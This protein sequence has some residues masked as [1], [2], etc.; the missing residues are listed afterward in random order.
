MTTK[1]DNNNNHHNF[2][3]LTIKN[4]RILEHQNNIFTEEINS[5]LNNNSIPYKNYS[6][7]QLLKSYSQTKKDYKKYY[8]NGKRRNTSPLFLKKI[9]LKSHKK[10]SKY[11]KDNIYNEGLKLEGNKSYENISLEKYLNEIDIYM[12][13][14]ENKLNENNLYYL[15][16]NEKNNLTERLKLTPIP[17]KSRIL[18]KTNK[19]INDLSS[20]ER[21]AVMLRRVEYTHGFSS[22]NYKNQFTDKLNRKRKQIYLIMKEAVLIIENWWKK[23]LDKRNFNNESNGINCFNDKLN[24]RNLNLIN[25]FFKQMEIFYYMKRNKKRKKKLFFTFIGKLRVLKNRYLKKHK[26]DSGKSTQRDSKYNEFEPVSNLKNNYNSFNSINN[27]ENNNNNDTYNSYFSPKKEKEIEYSNEIRNKI[28]LKSPK[29]NNNNNKNIKPLSRE[30]SIN[31]IILENGATL[32][33]G[34]EEKVI[35]KNKIKLIEANSGRNNNIKIKSH[36]YSSPKSIQLRN[37]FNSPLI[38]KSG[39]VKNKFFYSNSIIKNKEKEKEKEKNME[40]KYKYLIEKNRN[41]NKK[42]YNYY[43]KKNNDYNNEI[44]EEIKPYKLRNNKILIKNNDYYSNGND[45][46]FKDNKMKNI[47]KENNDNDE[48]EK[49]YNESLSE[50]KKSNDLKNELENEEEELPFKYPNEKQP[51]KLNKY[52]NKKS[53]NHQND[54]INN[55]IENDKKK[56]KKSNNS[57]LVNSLSSN[58]ITKNQKIKK[59]NK[60]IRQEDISKN[61]EKIIDNILRIRKDNY[62]DNNNENIENKKINKNN[63]N[64]IKKNNKRNNYLNDSKNSSN[65]SLNK[66]LSKLNS[67]SIRN[68]EEKISNNASIKNKQE[69]KII[70]IKKNAN[71]IKINTSEEDETIL[72]HSIEDTLI[73]NIKKLQS[74]ET[75]EVVEVS[76]EY[77]IINLTNEMNNNKNCKDCNKNNKLINLHL[78]E[79]PQF[80]DDENIKINDEEYNKKRYMISNNITNDLN[81]E[82]G[83]LEKKTIPDFDEL[84]LKKQDDKRNEINKRNNN[85][86][87]ETKPIK[88]D[89]ENSEDENQYKKNIN[90]EKPNSKDIKLMSIKTSPKNISTIRKLLHGYDKGNLNKYSYR[91]EKKNK[92]LIPKNISQKYLC[93]NSSNDYL[94]NSDYENNI[95]KFSQ[96]KLRLMNSL[97]FSFLPNY[98]HSLSKEEKM[99]KF[100]F[101]ILHCKKQEFFSRLVL[102]Y[103][104]NNKIDLNNEE[105]INLLKLG[106]SNTY[107]KILNNSLKLNVT[108]NDYENNNISFKDWVKKF[109]KNENDLENKDELTRKYK[110]FLNI[111]KIVKREN[112]GKQLEENQDLL[113]NISKTNK[114]ISNNKIDNYINNKRNNLKLFQASKKINSN[115]FEM[116]FNTDLY[117]YKSFKNKKIVNLHIRNKRD[118]S[119]DIIMP[120][121]ISDAYNLIKKKGKETNYNEILREFNDE[122]DKF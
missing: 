17:S 32:I 45:L 40:E 47:N 77:G 108:K 66:S 21:S 70:N 2:H 54:I 115:S 98:Q 109:V 42:I 112:N 7:Q 18:I 35:K 28:F 15:Y 3:I 63:L 49:D 24:K 6:Y 38:N 84:K 48:Y 107:Q 56:D 86:I 93:K 118:T 43:P 117:F 65:Q 62:K 79:K 94:N 120:K 8:S 116:N 12:E 72:N 83:E 71:K 22:N 68:H 37:L 4:N 87:E 105:L 96:N 91:N 102:Y 1:Y 11:F 99:K 113:K 85:V 100:I 55:L 92:T 52:N 81:V 101:L 10:L 57:S 27:N 51:Y 46:I 97:N 73:K 50:E 14:I 30:E 75:E 5:K 106:K 110:M 74:S 64:Q 41:A 39:K 25:N 13:H 122:P 58:S 23:I 111:T 114:N 26:I 88:N 33:I 19:E 95:S 103:L 53:S 59:K 34:R 82:T 29:S 9:Y 61:S 119:N 80:I 121:D 76:D 78:I 90:F 31:Q 104:Q 67:T 20:A 89:S 36:I 16:P 69:K 44:N 60:N